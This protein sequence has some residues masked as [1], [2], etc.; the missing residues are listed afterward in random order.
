MSKLL[1]GKV[2]KQRNKENSLPVTKDRKG[3]EIDA[4]GASRPYLIF[5]SNDKVY[6]LSTKSRTDKNRE[7]T[8]QDE[9]NVI[10]KK[11]LYDNDKEIAINCLAINVMDM[12][13]F[14]SLYEEDNEL[15]NSPAS[16]Y[17]YDKVMKKLHE[18]LKNIQYFEIKK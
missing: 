6:Y 7:L 17:T 8:T 9:E 1:I 11:N 16:A 2:Y 18:N 13:L 5:Y 4:Y 12:E 3:N 10:L 15:N 14:E